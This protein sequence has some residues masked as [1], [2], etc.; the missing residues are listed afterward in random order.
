MVYIVRRINK[1]KEKKG[2]SEILSK[3]HLKSTK[4]CMHKRKKVFLS[5]IRWAQHLKAGQNTQHIL[6]SSQDVYRLDKT[7]YDRSFLQYGEL[8]I[9]EFW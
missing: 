4:K 3:K 1:N 6:Q 5:A 8:S 7:K 9:M 2:Y